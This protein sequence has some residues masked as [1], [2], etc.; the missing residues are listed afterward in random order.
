[1]KRR[2]D[3]EREGEW[4]R[5]ES[6]EARGF[7]AWAMA[8]RF[9]NYGKEESRGIRCARNE[10]P[11]EGGDEEGG[12]Q[13]ERICNRDERKEEKRKRERKECQDRREELDTREAR[14]EYKQGGREWRRRRTTAR[15][16][17]EDGRARVDS[18]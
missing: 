4:K 14:V 8:K 9:S 5:A 2:P 17:G 13:E 7:C 12:S 16:E 3:R 11:E 6:Q 1:M 18:F 15:G 10:R